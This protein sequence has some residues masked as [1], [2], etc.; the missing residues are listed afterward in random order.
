MFTKNRSYFVRYLDISFAQHVLWCTCETNCLQIYRC[1]GVQNFV[2]YRHVYEAFNGHKHGWSGW[3]GDMLD[4]KKTSVL[5]VWKGRFLWCVCVSPWGVMQSTAMGSHISGTNL[6]SCIGK[7]YMLNYLA[8]ENIERLDFC[9]ILRQ[10]QITG[11]KVVWTLLWQP[12]FSCKNK[13][14]CY[15]NK[16]F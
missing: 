8:G 2:R 1:K 5:S 16:Y 3:V 10:M 9:Y 11:T 15:E 13:Y 14:L 4:G 6:L 7:G 12:I